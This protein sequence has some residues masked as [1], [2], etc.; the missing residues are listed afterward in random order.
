VIS[1][2]I[3]EIQFIDRIGSFGSLISQSLT[4]NQFT[5]RISLFGRIISQALSQNNVISSISNFFRYA[6]QTITENSS[7]TRLYGVVRN[8][9]QSIS[10]NVSLSQMSNFLRLLT[11]TVSE[12]SFTR[13]LSSFGRLIS[14]TIT[15]NS[16]YNAIST[17]F[18]KFSQGITEIS[19]ATRFF[20][21]IRNLSQSITANVSQGLKTNFLR[22][23]YQA[24]SENPAVKTLSSFYKNVVATI[25]PQNVINS[26]SVQFRI[27]SQKL[28]TSLTSL[29]NPTIIRIGNVILS[30]NH[31]IQRN[32]DFFKNIGQNISPSILTSRLAQITKILSQVF[33]LNS[34]M[35]K[36]SVMVYERLASIGIDLNRVLTSSFIRTKILTQSLS[37]E[38]VTARIKSFAILITNPIQVLLN[39]LNNLMAGQQPSPGPTPGPTPLGVIG[40]GAA[41]VSAITPPPVGQ[42]VDFVSWDILKEVSPTK[43]TLTAITIKNTLNTP[44]TNLSVEIGGVPKE[45]VS[46]YPDILSV[47]ASEEK[48]FNLAFAVPNETEPG[49]YKVDIKISN[50]EVTSNTFFILRVRP[51]ATFDR[52]VFYRNVEIDR[53]QNKTN[54]Q[55]LVENPSQN[56]YDAIE[57]VENIPKTLSG[58][59][60]EIQFNTE[61][62]EIIIKDPLVQWRMLNF[63]SN[64]SRT[65]SFTIKKV[66]EDFSVY[67]FNPLEQVNL[68]KETIPR[69]IRITNFYQPELVQG[70]SSAFEFE[71]KNLEKEKLNFT[72]YLNM[73]TDSK[74]TPNPAAVE[75]KSGEVKRIK[76][77]ISVPRETKL[78]TYLLQLDFKWGLS[79]TIK[80][81]SATVGII[82]TAKILIITFGAS[83][84]I[85]SSVVSYFTIKKGKSL[86]PKISIHY[87]KIK[88][89]KRIKIMKLQELKSEN[90][91]INLRRKLSDL[92]YAIKIRLRLIRGKKV[93]PKNI[94]LWL[95]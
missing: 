45:W 3:T 49:D 86:I 94:D 54:I 10:S 78:G 31:S 59:S 81:F 52:P 30:F 68:I 28:T 38:M 13:R 41:P 44:M 23:F 58:S 85:I 55:I 17:Y 43:T 84:V 91:F 36:T 9:R 92:I 71:L 66:V 73:P 12:N 75:L 60:D 89:M 25:S 72:I 46:V 90:L 47:N 8:I 61:P 51:S 79:E 70:E 6:S 5:G 27:A 42:K 95:T 29:V 87:E 2:S 93:P 18:R 50:K 57:V 64:E 53:N 35:I 15:E 39:L 32:V 14:Q 80:E 24:I 16:F 69:G 20:A 7:L 11:Q 63:S 33:N 74:V 88:V 76:F 82:S 77:E 26:M 48:T 21:L 56:N 65:I 67:I 83:V 37:V 4:E 1:Q 19:G 40:G 34:L 22:V 62:S